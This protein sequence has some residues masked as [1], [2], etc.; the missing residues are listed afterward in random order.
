MNVLDK[1][2]IQDAPGSDLDLVRLDD[3]DTA[4][5]PA[6]PHIIEKLLPVGVAS[7]L[8][9]H[10]GRGK[11]TLSLHAAVSV[12][13]GRPFMGLQVE[14]VPVL[15]Y[16]AE[17]GSDVIRY[18]LKQI[19][20]RE[21]ISPATLA[22]ML[23]VI[24]ATEI[25]PALFIERN[26]RDDFGST[27]RGLTTPAFRAL[28]DKAQEAQAR[29]VIIDNAS[30]TFEANEN[31]RARV[32]GFIRALAQLA[33]AT[34]G[35]VLLLSHV[36]KSTAK[37][38]G[39]SEGYSGS[40]AWHNSVRSRMFLHGEGRNL[41]LEHQKANFGPRADDL[42]MHWNFGVLEAGHVEQSES[43]DTEAELKH[44]AEIL[45]MI[46][47]RSERGQFISTSTTA[48]N[49]WTVLSAMTEF[50]KIDR[51][52]FWRL[53]DQAEN[54]GRLT[55]ETYQDA[56]RKSKERFTVNEAGQRFIQAMAH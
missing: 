22:K 23:H 10:G 30:D 12:A 5:I 6:P 14:Q 52:T 54:A 50:P 7:S 40:T 32:R 2:V 36:D 53:M 26:E 43:R 13:T 49:A 41:T 24:D 55:R 38:G 42:L 25:D 19:I 28:T 1:P 37:A 8:A 17:D 27:R 48:G 29:L 3:L 20:E 16:S 44:T 34:D 35:A 4:E 39:S 31:E 46:R 18:R 11:T 56:N 15:V 47:H 33:R 45:D 9:S 21:F 51:R